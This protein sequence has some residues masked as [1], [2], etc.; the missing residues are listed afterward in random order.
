MAK[1]IIGAKLEEPYE[2]ASRSTMKVALLTGGQDPQYARGLLRGLLARGI[3]VACVGSDELASCDIVSSGRLEFHNLVGSQRTDHFIAKAWRVLRYYGRLVTFAARTD[4]KLFHILWFRK[5]RSMERTLLNAYFKI[6]GKKLL[7]TAHNV[8][9][10]ARDGRRT[11]PVDRLSLR[12]LYRVVDHVLV[13][14][15]KMKRELVDD[16]KVAEQK[17]TIVPYGINDVIPVSTASRSA[18]KERLGLQPDE[19]VLL[20]FGNIAPYKGVEDLLE[21]L[22]M[23]RDGHKR[24]TLV[25]A[26]R[27]KDKS[28][29]SYWTKLQALIDEYQLGG[30]ILKEVRYIPDEDVGVF[31]RASDVTVLPYRRIYQSGVLALSYAQGLPVIAANVGSL[32]EDVV[33]GKTGLVFRSGDPANLAATILDYFSSDLFQDL[34]AKGQNIRE[35]G[36]ERFSWAQNVDRTLSAYEKLLVK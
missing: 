5:F 31:F 17:V 26:G 12:Y 20:F 10:R 2:G 36:A 18:A 35:Y 19:R 8:D 13:H 25:L 22:A 28:C 1:K 7:F 27:V 23:L 30:Q 21:A 9:D 3:D 33:E 14:T 34:D 16:F 32:S 6:L 29:E 24:F 4:A 11:G 15:P